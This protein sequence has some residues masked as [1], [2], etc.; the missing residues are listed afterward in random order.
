MC[1]TPHCKEPTE[2]SKQLFP[3]KELSS[4][5]PNFHIH[6]SVS[7]LYIPRIGPHISCSRI[8]RHMNIGTE[9]AQFLEKENI[10][11][12]FVSV[13]CMIVRRK[14]EMPFI[15]FVTQV[16]F[17]GRGVCIIRALYNLIKNYSD[18]NE[19]GG[20][21]GETTTAILVSDLYLSH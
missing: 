12:I 6:V 10:N 11:G 4:L 20:E 5:S 2:N 17:K 18:A 1:N 3:E 21:E 15:F 7:D 9:T 8:G 14:T 13:Y 16:S 19:G